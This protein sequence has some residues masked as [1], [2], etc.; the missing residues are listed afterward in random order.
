MYAVSDCFNAYRQWLM[1]NCSDPSNPGDVYCSELKE[2][3][4]QC[5][6]VYTRDD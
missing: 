6:K 2:V 3:L 4:N 5:G 1:H